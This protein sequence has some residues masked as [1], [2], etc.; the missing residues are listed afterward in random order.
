M[1]YHVLELQCLGST[2]GVFCVRTCF[3]QLAGEGANDCLPQS[4]MPHMQ[5]I[6]L[7]CLPSFNHILCRA[8]RAVLLFFRLMR[9]DGDRNT[10]T[11]ADVGSFAPRV[12]SFCVE[13]LFFSFHLALI[14]LVLR[15]E[16]IV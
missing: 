13:L 14:T 6:A 16:L 12:T 11:R 8:P 1:L 2:Y 7:F 15:Y 9:V 5:C 3:D 10:Q 4:M